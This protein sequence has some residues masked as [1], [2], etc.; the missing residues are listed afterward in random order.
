M[1]KVDIYIAVIEQ[2]AIKE[3]VNVMDF[4]GRKYQSLGINIL[5]FLNS[6]TTDF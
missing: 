6:S 4:L 1:T 2:F 3:L 5:Q